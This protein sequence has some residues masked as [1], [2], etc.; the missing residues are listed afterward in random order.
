MPQYLIFDVSGNF[1]AS[2]DTSG[3]IPD[4]AVACTALQY[5]QAPNVAWQ[6]GQIV[7]ITPPASVVTAAEAAQAQYDALIAGGLTI[8]S[9]GTPAIN[10]AYGVQPSNQASFTSTEMAIQAGIVT[11][12]IE[13]LLQ[14]GAPVSIP[15]ASVFL[16]I[17]GAAYKFVDEADLA[18]AVAAGGGTATWPS[19][20]VA[21]S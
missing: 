10:G 5:A 16:E 13:Y 15:S 4:G 20:S 7:T 21:V 2:G 1:I 17:A 18:I 9:T 6:N 8:T 14:N 12:P 19:S 3:T 11:F